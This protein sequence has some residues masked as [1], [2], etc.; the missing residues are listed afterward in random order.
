MYWA[1]SLA[2]DFSPAAAALLALGAVVAVLLMVPL[3]TRLLGPLFALELSRAA[4]GGRINILRVAYAAALLIAL[5]VTFPSEST[6]TRM[7][8]Q[9]YAERFSSLFLTIQS[10]AALVMTPIV[11]GSAISG[12]RE[13][14]SL[15]FLL[16]TPLSAA[17]I[18]L[19][20]YFGWFLNITSVLLTGLPIL[21]LTIFWGGVDLEKIIIVFLAD[22][23]AVL[24]LGAIGICFS[25]VCQRRINAI[26]GA[27]IAISCFHCEFA[28]TP[29]GIQREMEIA[30]RGSTVFSGPPSAWVTVGLSGAVHASLVVLG[31][32]LSMFCLRQAGRQADRRFASL[33]IHREPDLAPPLQI[34][35]RA[36][37]RIPTNLRGD[38]LLWRERNLDY[39]NNPFFDLLWLYY[40]G[41]LFLL[42]VAALVIP[43]DSGLYLIGLV[44]QFS[45][46][47]A[48]TGLCLS[49]LL[50]LANCVSRERE[51]RTLEALLS[52]PVSR[53]RVLF[54]KWLGAGFRSNHWALALVASLTLGTICGGCGVVEGLLLLLLAVSWAA[55]VSAVALCASVFARTTVR[56]YIYATVAVL[57]V[58]AV[59]TFNAQMRPST[60]EKRDTFVRLAQDA[61]SPFHAWRMASRVKPDNTL[62]KSAVLPMLSAALLYFTTASVI[63]GIAFW[64]FRREDRYT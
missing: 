19:G 61:L 28:L 16:V 50:R 26:A 9:Q 55:C 4:R 43:D 27:A 31:L 53:P 54:A 21:A 14:R 60:V 57:A 38:A 51:H 30:P 20:K 13:K 17:E 10:I 58:A 48:A 18:V 47:F 37:L 23:L 33:A 2:F 40:S 42:V 5:F 8:L 12:E 39:F 11:F 34:R 32:S 59:T 29:I 6:L 64:R 25:A 52:M 44:F 1:D 15:D 46:A 45:G 49:L 63:A 24:G 3:S 7:E 41:L 56:A 62:A 22:M 36:T 35:E